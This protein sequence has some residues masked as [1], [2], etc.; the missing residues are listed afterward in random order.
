MPKHS[1]ENRNVER[2]FRI[3]QIPDSLACT[4]W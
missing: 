2:C 4:R 1:A 3:D